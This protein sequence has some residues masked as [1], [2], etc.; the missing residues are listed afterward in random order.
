MGRERRRHSLLWVVAAA[1][2]GLLSLVAVCASSLPSLRAVIERGWSFIWL[3]GPP[4]TLIYGLPG[5]AFYLVETVLL[6]GLALAAT[7][8]HGWPAV[9]V[10]GSCV[11][12]V[13][14]LS[15]FLAIAILT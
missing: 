5:V 7:K 9:V 8:R 2:Y 14:L 13:W 11:L 1:A 15:G 6:V 4:I 12:V 3:F 10:L